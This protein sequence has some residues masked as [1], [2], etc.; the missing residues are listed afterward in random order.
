VSLKNKKLIAIIEDDAVLRRGLKRFFTKE[1]YFVI[2]FEDGEKAADEILLSK[3]DL[4]LCDYK[5]PG[6]NGV[7]V[8]K[9]LRANGIET[10]FLLMTG[11]FTDQVQDSARKN[12]VDGTLE[13]PIDLL[14]LKVSCQKI[15]KR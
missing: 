5:L 1:S 10:P 8:L 2:D 9:K 11:Y 6:A 15:M 3:P 13:K 7:E 12:G 4:I 14:L